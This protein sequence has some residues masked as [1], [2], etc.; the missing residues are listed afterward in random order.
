M[1]FGDEL[2]AFARKTDR[3]VNLIVKK[4]VIDIGTA[5]VLKS[6]VGDAKYWKHPAPPGYVGGRFRANWQYGLDQIN[7]AVT[8]AVDPSGGATISAIVGKVSDNAAGHIHYITNGL[9]YAHRLE[10]G[11]SHRQA[12]NGMVALTVLEFEPIVAAAN[13][14]IP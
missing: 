11:W 13:A 4:V 14:A 2:E 5:V 10:D 7:E 1:S 3:R 12:P 9:P 8:E 6:P